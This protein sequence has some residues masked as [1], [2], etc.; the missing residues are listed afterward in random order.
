VRTGTCVDSKLARTFAITLLHG[1]V[2]Y[3][4]VTCVSAIAA[5]LSWHVFEVRFPELKKYFTYS[6]PE[7]RDKRSAVSLDTEVPEL[8]GVNS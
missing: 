6:T 3:L 2:Q 4:I 5:F 8:T 7:R 1:R